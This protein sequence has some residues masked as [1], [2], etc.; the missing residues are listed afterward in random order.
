VRPE[1]LCQSKIPMT[2]SGIERYSN[3]NNYYYYIHYLLL[4]L[5]LLLLGACGG[6]LVEVLRYKPE[7]HGIDSQ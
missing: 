2:P 4:L 6:A 7:G 5:L 1:G 3:N